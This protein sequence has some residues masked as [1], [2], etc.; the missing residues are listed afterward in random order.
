MKEVFGLECEVEQLVSTLQQMF[1]GLGSLAGLNLTDLIKTLRNGTKLAEN[2]K[3]AL[4][5]V[6]SSFDRSP[7][8]LNTGCFL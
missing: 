3:K 2:T 1:T 6:S 5:M 7:F 8:F 4:L